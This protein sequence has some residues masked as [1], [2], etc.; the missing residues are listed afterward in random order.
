[1][2]SINV[3]EWPDTPVGVLIRGKWEQEN[4]VSTKFALFLS[5]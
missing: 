2:L 4:F 1:M 3:F 5:P